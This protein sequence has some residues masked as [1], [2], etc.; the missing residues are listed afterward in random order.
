MQKDDCIFCKIAKGEIP[1]NKVYEDDDVVVFDDLEPLMPV[2]TLIIPKDHYSD[3]SDNV[4]PET[5]GKV[6]SKVGMVAEK[7]GLTNGYRVL[8]NT[9]EDASH[10]HPGR[11]PHAAP[12]RPGL[13]RVRHQRRRD[14]RAEGRGRSLESVATAG[15]TCT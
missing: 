1:T 9:G 12:E 14:R 2:H 13:G 3:L 8:V 6:F 11:R 7:K 10:A 4:P 15:V 5:L